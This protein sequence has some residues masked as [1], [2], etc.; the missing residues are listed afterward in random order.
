MKF[1]FGVLQECHL[2]KLPTHGLISGSLKTWICKIMMLIDV[3][4]FLVI[5]E[6]LWRS[7][8]LQL[9]PSPATHEVLEWRCVGHY[10]RTSKRWNDIIT[11]LFWC[12]RIGLELKLI[13]RN[14]KNYELDGTFYTWLMH[15]GRHDTWAAWFLIIYRVTNIKL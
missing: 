6:I 13:W 5:V 11:T 12:C 3:G 1:R 4:C 7:C 15:Y 9:L 10:E 2:F 14:W 8:L